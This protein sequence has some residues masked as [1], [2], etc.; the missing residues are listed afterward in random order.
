MIG[1]WDWSAMYLTCFAVGLV[2]SLVSFAG[3]FLHVHVGHFHLGASH[4]AA[5]KAT[6]H[7][8]P[9]NG[10]TLVAFLC[11]FGGTGYLLQGANVFASALVLLFSAVSGLAGASLVFWFLAK[12]L[13][14]RER[15]LQA[16]DTEIVGMIGRLS[17]AI[18]MRG[19]GEVLY[20]QNGARRSAAVRA[21]D[22]SAME[23]GTE[24]VVMRY[25]SGVAYVRRWDEF[26]QGLLREDTPQKTQGA[27]L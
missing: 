12:V 22:G 26:E 17:A 20:S 16:A 21:D 2:L 8:V 10:F 23:R 3:G 19:V 14:P 18:P 15:T 25:V 5:S 9:I 24:V 7:M 4:G 27:V 6:P 1:N 11:W 13:L